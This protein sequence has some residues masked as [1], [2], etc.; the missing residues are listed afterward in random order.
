MGFPQAGKRMVQQACP[1]FYLSVVAPGT[2][3]AGQS[4]TLE[5]GLRGLSI[6]DAFRAQRLK[7][8]R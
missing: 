2:I 7:H 4:F 3:Q 6:I 5:A 1:G 8:L